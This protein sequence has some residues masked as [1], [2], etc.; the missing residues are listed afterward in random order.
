MSIYDDLAAEWWDEHK[1]PPPYDAVTAQAERWW[2]WH[3]RARAMT[4]ALYADRGWHALMEGPVSPETPVSGVSM[5][6]AGVVGEVEGDEPSVAG[7]QAGIEAAVT[8]IRRTLT[9]ALRR[10]PAPLRPLWSGPIP[11]P[12]E[13]HS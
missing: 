6:E 1:R 4:H 3:G 13:D 10:L 7:A 5:I 11:L 12:P 9:D 8:E 2:L